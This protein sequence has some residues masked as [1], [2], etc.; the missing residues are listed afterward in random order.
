MSSEVPVAVAEGGE[1]IYVQVERG[2]P[3]HPQLA[4]VRGEDSVAT[5]TEDRQLREAH[6]R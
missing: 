4:R 3:L 1:V 6:A 2:Q 5:G